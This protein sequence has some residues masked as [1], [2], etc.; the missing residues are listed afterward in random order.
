MEDI[1]RDVQYLETTSKQFIDVNLEKEECGM[2]YQTKH[3]PCD[4]LQEDGNCKLGANRTIAKNIRIPI[5]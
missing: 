1:D 2:N 5:N 3:K 4:F